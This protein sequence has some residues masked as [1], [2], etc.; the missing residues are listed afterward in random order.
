MKDYEK[1]PPIV[2]ER[3]EGVYLYDIEGQRYLDAIF[4]WW[5]NLFGHANP[6]INQAI[7]RQL[8]KLEHFIFVN[9]SHLLAVK[10]AKH[11]I[12]ICPPGLGKIFFSDDGSTAVENAL[13]ISFQYYQQTGKPKKRKFAAINNSYHGE[14]LG[15]MSVNNIDRKSTV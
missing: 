1:F 4:S 13:K 3:G 7:A 11:L 10:L 2:L 6:R 15:A 9:F 14:T 8:D 12:E 5:V